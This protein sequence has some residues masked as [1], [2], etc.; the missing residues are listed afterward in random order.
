MYLDTTEIVYWSGWTELED[1]LFRAIFSVHK[2]FKDKLP[3]SNFPI[4]LVYLL[5]NA[6][7]KKKWET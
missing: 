4:P 6:D 3:I 2:V 7:A 5:Q 1:A